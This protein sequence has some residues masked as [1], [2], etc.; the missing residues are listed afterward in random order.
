MA[1]VCSLCA[2]QNAPAAKFCKKCGSPLAARAAAASPVPVDTGSEGQKL[3]RCF[4]C[5]QENDPKAR[6]CK[7]CGTMLARVNPI[8]ASATVSP[9]RAAATSALS[10]AK[11]P[12]IPEPG[13]SAGSGGK[14]IV[15]AA[16][17]AFVLLAL[18]GG[19]TYWW[20]NRKA[21]GTA[22]PVVTEPAPAPAAPPVAGSPAPQP[23]TPVEPPAPSLVVVP[24]PPPVAEP[25]PVS[26]PPVA[27]P[28]QAAPKRVTPPVVKA[29]RS[30]PPSP[31][32][33]T[34]QPEPGLSQPAAAPPPPI[35]RPIEQPAIPA[36][37]SSP[38]E[39]CGS[40]I[41]IALA[42]CMSEQCNAPQFHNHPQCV[43]LR[44]QN[45]RREEQSR[46]PGG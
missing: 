17:A 33:E 32:A 22:T 38:R 6:F 15:I 35:A 5:Q 18:A 13:R 12:L 25:P 7:K 3:V 1:N 41:F 40:R 34:V 19:G 23:P 21:P 27:P 14:A 42:L 37:P 31:R 16:A 24:E 9:A 45:R 4:S 46:N 28:R 30:A 2:T 26:V 29:P 20:M 36:G 44:E 39:A 11:P 10:P 43:Q 8:A